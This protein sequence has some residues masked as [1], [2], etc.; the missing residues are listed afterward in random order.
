MTV[1]SHHL[2][3]LDVTAS[4]PG[5]LSTRELQLLDAYWRAANTSR[6]VKSPLRANPPLREPLRLE[7][8]NPRLLGRWETARPQ[9]APRPPQLAIKTRAL[10]AMYVFGSGHGGPAWWRMSRPKYRGLPDI[11]R[12]VEGPVRPVPAVLLPRPHTRPGGSGDPWLR[13]RGRRARLRLGAR[14]APSEMAG[15][16]PIR[17]RRPP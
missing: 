10:A 3:A 15:E 14:L 16:R 8:V 1:G 7:H 17:P 9:P 13:P 4:A 11:S 2:T 12:D 5:L 6:S